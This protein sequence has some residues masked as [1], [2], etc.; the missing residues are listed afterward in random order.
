MFSVELFLQI[1]ILMQD[2]GE[3][4]RLLVQVVESLRS[5]TAER[6]AKD[7]EQAASPTEVAAGHHT[8]A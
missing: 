1:Q 4:G 2:V 7:K 6:L 8:Q 3:A 5:H